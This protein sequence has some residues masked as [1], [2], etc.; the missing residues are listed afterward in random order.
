MNYLEHPFDIDI[1]Y[2]G[3]ELYAVRSRRGQK[4][5]VCLTKFD[6]DIFTT[7][8]IENAKFEAI[9]LCCTAKEYG[10]YDRGFY[11]V[12]MDD[13][14]IWLYRGGP[15]VHTIEFVQICEDNE[16]AHIIIDYLLEQ[17]ND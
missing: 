12:E 6:S 17:P 16:E 1:M 5:Y 8:S 11:I 13:D 4:N 14:T 3:F 10:I 7:D 15:E 2:R 9:R